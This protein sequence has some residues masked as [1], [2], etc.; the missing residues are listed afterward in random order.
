MKRFFILITAIF[1]V[2]VAVSAQ[3]PNPLP[4]DPAVKVGKLENG[5]TYYIRHNDKPAQ[6]AEFYLATNV[7]AF[8]ETDAQDGLAHFLEHMCF[9]GTKNFPGKALLEYLQSIGAE[10][11]RNINA[12]TGFE[13]TQ[14]MLNNIPIVREGIIDSCLLIL[15]DY[16]H[17]VTCDPEEIDA[18]RGVILE[19]RRTRRDAN[20]RMFEQALPYY[21]GDT[22]YAK[23]TLIGGEEQLKTFEYRHLTDFYHTWYH[24]DMQAVIVVGDIDV[25]AIEQKI[26]DTFGDIPAPKTPTTKKMYQLPE[27]KEPIIGILTDPEA[28]GSSI[29]VMWKG[30]PLPEQ[31]NN[32]DM[33]YMLSLAK[34][35][36]GIIMQERFGD[37]TSQPDAPYLSGSFGIGNL[38][39]TCDVAMGDVSFKNGDAQTAFEAFMLEIEKMKRY[40]FTEAEVSRAK[41]MI[42]SSIERSVNSAETRQN[43]DFVPELLKNFYD[44][45]S[46]LEPKFE[47][48]LAQAITSQLNNAILNQLAS[49]VIT[50]ENMI[51]LF[52]GPEKEGLEK[53]DEAALRAILNKV[54]TADI[55]ANKEES[56]DE[57][58]L[59][60]SKLKGSKIK[61]ESRGIYDTYEWTLANGMKVIVLPTEYEKD[62]IRIDIFKEGGKNLIKT[63]DL[64]SFDDNIWGLYLQNTGISKFPKTTVKKM[65][66]GKNISVSPFIGTRSHGVKAFSTPKDLETALQSIY[67]YYA[68][69]RFDENEF[70]TGIQQIKAILPN[71]EKQPGF[72]FQNEITKTLYGSSERTP[73][74]NQ[75]LIDAASLETIE[76]NYRELFKDASGTTAIIVGHVDI[77]TLKPMVQKYLGSIA[78]GKKSKAIKDI[79][80]GIV[81]GNVINHWKQ[82]MET[83][84]TTVVQL[85]TAYCP[86]SEKTQAT[87]DVAKYILDMIYVRTMR[88]EVGGTYGAS[89]AMETGKEPEDMVLLQVYFDTNPDTADQLRSLAIEGMNQLATDGPTEEEMNKAIGNL[90]KN[91]PEDRIRNNYWM[92][93]IKNF[94][95]Y[96]TDHD[97]EYEKA[98]LS[99]TSEDVKTLLQSV[100]AQKNFIEIMMEPAK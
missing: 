26:K 92:S 61:K 35:Y 91:I 13:E 8:Q 80:P 23:R 95:K 46:Y 77:E 70:Q 87:L 22:P 86:V 93:N 25:D 1:A 47:L 45:E 79:T 36:I 16:S 59:D 14:Y 7:G 55:Q 94:H 32:T 41:D 17:F 63:E 97:A 66:A 82:V 89:V 31:F 10:F 48:Q 12:S 67:L 84:K 76:S 85:Y 21:Y 11:G 51:I 64:A 78:K 2:S 56:I 40:G 52:N 62:E 60:E 53:P 73:E 96:G 81:K 3:G 72:K 50:D 6:R 98:L 15:H 75:A 69:P 88:E 71:I 33:A 44:N 34:A 39:E 68:D 58:L 65:I 99:V 24:P 49:Q 83:P 37:I 4:N 38:C 9:N 100:I 18:E 19:E 27:N 28:K 29:S 5:L 43:S 30:E 42:I 20:W 74:L 57:P 90:K 54:K